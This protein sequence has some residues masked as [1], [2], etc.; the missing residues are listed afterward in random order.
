MTEKSKLVGFKVSVDEKTAIVQYAGAL[1][2]DLSNF[3]RLCVFKELKTQSLVSN[4]RG[5]NN[6]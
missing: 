3:V 4:Q 5:E 2:M 1:G 6:D